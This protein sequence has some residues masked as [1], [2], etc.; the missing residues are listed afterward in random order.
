L[1]VN[2]AINLFMYF[3][4]YLLNTRKGFK[5]TVLITVSK[6]NQCLILYTYIHE[7]LHNLHRIKFNSAIMILQHTVSVYQLTNHF[8]GSD[9]IY[10]SINAFIAAQRQ[11]QR[12]SDNTKPIAT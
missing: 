2:I 8:R 7:R 6:L 4:K 3:Y 10:Q 9:T 5:I 11:S 1:H 12:H